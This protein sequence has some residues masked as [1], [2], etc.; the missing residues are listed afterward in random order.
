[1]TTRMRDEPVPESLQKKAPESRVLYP[2]SYTW[3]CELEF[4]PSE[5][6]KIILKFQWGDFSNRGGSAAAANILSVH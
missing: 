5:S 2:Y 6:K 4:P 3:V 1:M